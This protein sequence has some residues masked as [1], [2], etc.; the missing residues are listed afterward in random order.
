MEKDHLKLLN[1]NIANV[2]KIQS[3]GTPFSGPV[4]NSPINN[5]QQNLNSQ[6]Q[7]PRPQPQQQQQ[8]QHQQQQ[9]PRPPRP[10]QSNVI[11]GSGGNVQYIIE[12][13]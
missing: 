11:N 1:Q 5:P 13:A 4:N 2:T 9:P 6:P 8:Q 12:G 3:G 7:P 10:P